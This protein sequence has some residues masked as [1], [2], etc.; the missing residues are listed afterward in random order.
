[1]AGPRGFRQRLQPRSPEA[2]INRFN[3]QVRQDPNFIYQSHSPAGNQYDMRDFS[4][5]TGQSTKGISQKQ[6]NDGPIDFK[7]MGFENSYFTNP[8]TGQKY[9]D[10][11]A[12][13]PTGWLEDRRISP[14]ASGTGSYYDEGGTQSFYP[15]QLKGPQTWNYDPGNSGIM[16]MSPAQQE[17]Y[18]TADASGIFNL[19]DQYKDKFGEYDF[20][21]NE[22]SYNYDMPLGPGN[23]NVGGSYNIESRI[24]VIETEVK[25]I[26]QKLDK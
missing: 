4:T 18:Q 1:M 11:M 9:G 8:R 7:H 24:A 21:D 22:Y 10:S 25:H 3:T 12:Q 26:N 20:A 5:Y 14:D 13:G 16:Q 6:V 15:I 19:Y 23:L 2:Q 17:E